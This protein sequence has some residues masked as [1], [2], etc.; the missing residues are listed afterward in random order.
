MSRIQRVTG[1][2]NDYCNR[3][4]LTDGHRINV[5]AQELAENFNLLAVFADCRP[6]SIAAACV[7]LVCCY[8]AEYVTYQD[9]EAIAAVDVATIRESSYKLINN[10]MPEDG[11]C[12]FDV[13]NSALHN[14]P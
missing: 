6:E 12:V 10:G 13:M 14:H 5:L 2:C 11:I 3:L 1:L 8:M 7:Y 9:L 4:S